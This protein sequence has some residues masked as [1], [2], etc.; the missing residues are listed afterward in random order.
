MGAK[1]KTLVL[2]GGG[3]VHL[4]VLKKLKKSPIMDYE[5]LLIS[6]ASKQFYSGMAA[7]YLEGIYSE[8]DFTVDLQSYCRQSGVDFVED[9]AVHIDPQGKVLTTQRGLTIIYDVLSLDIGSLPDMSKLVGINENCLPLKPLYKLKAIQD[10][11]EKSQPLQFTVLGA[12]ASGVEVACALKAKADK[13]KRALAITVI[14]SGDDVLKGYP[15]VAKK[16]VKKRLNALNIELQLKT[17]ITELNKEGGYTIMAT[18]SVGHRLLTSLATPLDSRGFM[19]VNDYLQ[20]ERYP[21]LFG[22]G[23]CVTLKN[24]MHL[25]KL[26]VYAIKEAPVLWKNINHFINQ[27]KLKPF[28]PQKYYLSLISMGNKRGILTYGKFAIMSRWAWH[29]KTWI[30]S[31]YMKKFKSSKILLK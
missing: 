22:A 18:G 28:K 25:P 1:K 6:A 14:D 2:V 27:E 5:V 29:L 19:L 17:R 31:G 13:A 7:G 26:G 3:H 30:D 15:V 10:N 9:E 11:F 24:H 21:E 4:Y 16:L 12:G 8:S 20:N 23:D